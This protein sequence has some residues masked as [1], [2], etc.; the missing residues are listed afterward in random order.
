MKKLAIILSVAG[1]ILAGCVFA[2]KYMIDGMLESFAAGV[3]ARSVSIVRCS[4]PTTRRVKVDYLGFKPNGSYEIGLRLAYEEFPA[5]AMEDRRDQLGT[6][7]GGGL[8]GHQVYYAIPVDRSGK[9]LIPPPPS[10]AESGAEAQKN[11][12]GKRDYPSYETDPEGYERYFKSIFVKN[13]VIQGY[14]YQFVDEEGAHY[15]S[16]YFDIT[17]W[18]EGDAID[19]QDRDAGRIDR[20]EPDFNQPGVS[21]TKRNIWR[22]PPG[23]DCD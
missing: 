9:P 8:D 5:E 21:T 4:S 10:F 6:I 20:Y 23:E 14:E 11:L 13:Y 16:P 7:G 12:Y 1:V 19:D 18:S 22:I 15:R 17:A 2:A 3:P